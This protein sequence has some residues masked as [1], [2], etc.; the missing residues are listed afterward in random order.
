MLLLQACM[1]SPSPSFDAPVPPAPLVLTF[2]GDIMAHDVN[3]NMRD[4][5]M[6]YRDVREM[7]HSDDLSFANFETPVA[8]RLPMSTYPRFNVHR[9]YLEAAVSGGFDVFSLA[10][11]HTNDQGFPGMTGTLHAVQKLPK[12]IVANGIRTS[13][14]DPLV[15]TVIKKKDWTIVFLA[16]T[17]ILNSHDASLAQVQYSPPTAAGRNALKTRI[18]QIVAS[19]PHSLFILSLHTNEPEYVR[20]V[21]TR[22]KAWFVELAESGVDIVWAHHPHVMQKWEVVPV[23]G[24]DCL[25]MYS[26]GN[27][28]SGQRWRVNHANPA[29]DREYTGDSVLLQ[30]LLSGD[31]QT[32]RMRSPVIQPVPITN[33]RDTAHG[34]V[35]KRYSQT[36]LESLPESLAAYYRRRLVLMND[37][38]PVLLTT[39]QPTILTQ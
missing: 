2:A 36:F 34:M 18:E 9:T 20:S 13:V 16:V 17:E 29:S 8:D 31:A 4:Y 39:T 22:K 26:M 10:N 37:Y 15:P 28:I 6:I 14:G 27:F 23:K 11:N 38:L 32:G 33:H 25:F 1:S 5:S 12:N 21:S 30:V 19:H 35:V 7:L 24:R 3:F